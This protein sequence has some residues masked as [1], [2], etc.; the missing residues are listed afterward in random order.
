MFPGAFNPLHAGH[1][2]MA[3]IAAERLGS[4]VAYEISIENVDKPPTDFIEIDHRLRQFSVGEAVWLTR[5]PTFVKKAAL[6]PG[7]TFVVGADT[8]ERVGQE[9][10]YGHRA[11]LDEAI[12]RIAAAG[13]R[14]LVFGRAIAGTFRTLEDLSLP[15]GLAAL[16]TGVPAEAF[17]EDV[18]STEIRQR[19]QAS[20]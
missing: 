6:F 7:A 3:E 19:S 12:S 18:S 9:R 17:R 8:I 4:D 15:A 20:P 16:C 14:F 2:K 5:A 11:A 10:Y 1:R 13:C